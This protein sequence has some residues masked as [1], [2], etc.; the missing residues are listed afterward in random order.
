MIDKETALAEKEHR[1]PEIVSR[2]FF[3]K[4]LTLLVAV[5]DTTRTAIIWALKILS[6]NPEAQDKLRAELRAVYSEAN[7]KKRYPTVREINRI[8]SHYRDAAIEGI[9]RRSRTESALA[10][11]AMVDVELLG[12]RIPKGTGVFSMGNG[13]GFFAPAFQIK[14]LRS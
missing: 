9:I 12:H 10:S 11:T 2:K 5:H 7:A 13:P 3:D 6:D 4:I 14:G 8:D 1:R